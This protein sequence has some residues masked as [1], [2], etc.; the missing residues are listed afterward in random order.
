MRSA[1][2]V[3]RGALVHQVQRHFIVVAQAAALTEYGAERGRDGGGYSGPSLRRR[4]A[5]AVMCCA[6][7]RDRSFSHTGRPAPHQLH[8]HRHERL[9]GDEVALRSKSP[10]LQFAEVRQLQRVCSCL[11]PVLSLQPLCEREQA[12][13]TL[14]SRRHRRRH[15]G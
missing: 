12:L 5:G 9:A 2:A 7:P 1:L 3:A 14:L 8:G 15:G 10:A 6:Q 11:R 13:M 4:V